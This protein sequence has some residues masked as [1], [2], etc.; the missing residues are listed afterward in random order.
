M[1]DKGINF[2]KHKKNNYIEHSLYIKPKT[3]YDNFHIW[4]SIQC[5]IIYELC[6]E[7][8]VI[9]LIND[10]YFASIYDNYPSKQ[11]VDDSF[12]HTSEEKSSDSIGGGSITSV[13]SNFFG[14][15]NLFQKSKNLKSHSCSFNGSIISFDSIDK[16][17]ILDF[18]NGTSIWDSSGIL[19]IYA[20]ESNVWNDNLKNIKSI[21]ELKASKFSFEIFP[22]GD[23]LGVTISTAKE[24]NIIVN[25]IE[26][27]IQQYSVK[28]DI[29][30]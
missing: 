26:K 7:K 6:K 14:R 18:I 28:L 30:D 1:K 13:T 10:S 4:D 15:L 3:Q 12:N 9:I 29:I 5:D 2:E 25:I 27:V 21:R 20:Y 24:N 17:I 23:N 11:L 22:M 19:N 8:K 16:N